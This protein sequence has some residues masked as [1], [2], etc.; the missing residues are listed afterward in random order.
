MAFVLFRAVGDIALKK[1]VFKKH[2]SLNIE[3]IRNLIGLLTSFYFWFG[4][5]CTVLGVFFWFVTLQEFDLSYAYPFLS[6][7]Y[8]LIILSGKV[9]FK[10]HLDRQK[11]IG[12]GFISV[13]ILCLFLG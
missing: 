4:I 3:G 5:L 12:I 8:I 7:A 9:L 6:L 11:C 13:G 2:M 1:S 10:E